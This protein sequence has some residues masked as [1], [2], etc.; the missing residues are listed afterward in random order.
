MN[1]ILIAD[2]VEKWIWLVMSNPTAQK[3]ISYL[4]RTFMKRTQSLEGP[5]LFGHFP[6]LYLKV[7]WKRTIHY[8]EVKRCKEKTAHY[9]KYEILVLWGGAGL[10]LVH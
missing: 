10:D 6:Y 8:D 7:Y 4:K 9:M 3:A 2:R 1:L 5:R